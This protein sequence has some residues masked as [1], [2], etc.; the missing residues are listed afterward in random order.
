MGEV[1]E[2]DLQFLIIVKV[3]GDDGTDRGWHGKFGRGDVLTG[4]RVQVSRQ[5]CVCV[6]SKRRDSPP[7]TSP[8]L[9][10]TCGGS[11]QDHKDPG[12]LIGQG[13]ER[14][15]PSSHQQSTWL[16]LV[17]VTRSPPIE[18][19]QISAFPFYRQGEGVLG[20]GGE[21]PMVMAKDGAVAGASDSRCYVHSSS[22]GESEAGVGGWAML[23]SALHLN[24]GF[25]PDWPCDLRQVISLS[26]LTLSVSN[27]GL[28]IVW[29]RP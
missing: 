29:L 14:N 12:L 5:R 18:V 8:P 2:E 1:V 19:R 20:E 6:Q 15:S 28:G 7:N 23:E 21:S 27:M 3:S 26:G 9:E 4:E 17:R 22:A 13:G 25:S 11:T 10:G 16:F 24:P